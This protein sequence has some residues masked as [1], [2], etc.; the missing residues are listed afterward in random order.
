GFWGSRRGNEASGGEGIM[1]LLTPQRTGLSGQSLASSTPSAGGDTFRNNGRCMVRLVNPAGGSPLVV[2]FKDYGT[3]ALFGAIA[4][5]PDVS[6]TIPVGQSRYIG[7][8]DPQR[9]NNADGIAS[10][11]YTGPLT[12]TVTVIQIA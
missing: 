2:K 5:D 7:P 9:F 10:M 11:T 8:F 1:A 6:V 3:P 12:G 4:F